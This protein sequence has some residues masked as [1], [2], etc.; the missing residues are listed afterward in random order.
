MNDKTLGQLSSGLIASIPWCCVLPAVLSIL[1]L[2]GVVPARL[3]AWKLNPILLGLTAVFLARAHYLLYWK[4]HGNRLS[5]YLT[6][7]S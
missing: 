1:G 4:G 6:W 3:V 5:Q 7:G 2:S